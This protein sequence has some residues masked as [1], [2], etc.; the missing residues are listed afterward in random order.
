L[1]N[2]VKIISVSVFAVYTIISADDILSLLVSTCI[3]FLMYM[4]NG[5][6]F[7]IILKRNIAILVFALF[8]LIFSSIPGFSGESKA[9]IEL[10][11]VFFRIIIIYNI[12]FSGSLWIGRQG[13]FETIGGIMPLRI[14]LF[15]VLL[16]HSLAQF[17][18]I[19]SMIV[20]QLKSRLRLK[21]RNRILVARYY[22]QNLII[23]ELYSLHYNQ[24]ALAIRLNDNFEM[25]F[26]R[27]GIRLSDILIILSI[28][29]KAVLSHSL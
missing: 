12:I 7:K 10:C 20:Y 14:R 24:A 4:C 9:F 22:F 3:V 19:N 26:E 6:T 25:Y 18:K 13:F 11:A 29:I 15:L 16:N 5:A 21:G 17:I 27:N 28:A 1:L 8:F 2:S 23:K